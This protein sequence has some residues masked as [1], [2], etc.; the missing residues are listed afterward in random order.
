M[1]YIT[2]SFQFSMLKRILTM[3]LLPLLTSASYAS[4][5]NVVIWQNNMTNMSKLRAFNGTATA[6][7]GHVELTCTT[8]STGIVLRKWGSL[9]VKAG[10]ELRID[11]NVVKLPPN[12]KNFQSIFVQIGGVATFGKISVTDKKPRSLVYKFKKMQPLNI[13]IFVH[14]GVKEE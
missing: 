2:K 11:F 9:K 7:S 4:D 6:A 14:I 10:S 1:C 3:L 12:D 13:Y 5:E 8:K